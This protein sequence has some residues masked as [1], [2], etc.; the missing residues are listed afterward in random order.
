MVQQENRSANNFHPTNRNYNFMPTTI[1]WQYPGNVPLCNLIALHDKHDESSNYEQC[2][3]T[4]I[5][6]KHSQLWQYLLYWN[7]LNNVLLAD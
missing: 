5:F 2:K 1:D 4:D 7:K 6:D 3:V